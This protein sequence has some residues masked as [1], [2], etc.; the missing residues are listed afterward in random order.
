[1]RSVGRPHGWEARA[2]LVSGGDRGKWGPRPRP[3]LGLT[4]A[5]LASSPERVSPGAPLLALAKPTCQDAE[6]RVPAVREPAHV[7]RG[8]RESP[9]PPPSWSRPQTRAR[10]RGAGWQGAGLAHTEQ[11][12]A[13]DTVSA[14]EPCPLWP[15]PL[16]RHVSVCQGWVRLRSA[17]ALPS[18]SKE[19]GRSPEVR[20][21]TPWQCPKG[22]RGGL[23]ATCHEGR[24]EILQTGSRCSRGRRAEARRGEGSWGTPLAMATVGQLPAGNR[25]SDPPP[26]GSWRTGVPPH[27]GAKLPNHPHGL[28]SPT[29][30]G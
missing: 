1:M 8:A 5:P 17:V 24:A 27:A 13:A 26:A 21:A 23:P 15:L 9:P 16:N 20:A 30:A 29:P 25:H 12:K 6:S 3:R 4:D 7:A 2:S 11:T 28:P 10:R 18:E 14:C 22:L 19:M